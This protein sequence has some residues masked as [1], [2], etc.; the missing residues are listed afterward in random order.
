MPNS[1][2][3]NRQAH[4]LR[5]EEGRRCA[6]E[7]VAHDQRAQGQM[8]KVDTVDGRTTAAAPVT[9]VTPALLRTHHSIAATLEDIGPLT[10]SSFT[11]T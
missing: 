6:L 10:R 8:A 4:P 1:P 5:V 11:Q 2:L 7:P 9:T 3:W